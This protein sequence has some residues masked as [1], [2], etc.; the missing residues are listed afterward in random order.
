MSVVT[1]RSLEVCTAD[2]IDARIDACRVLDLRSRR[3]ESASTLYTASRLPPDSEVRI[4]FK[5]GE[6]SKG[7]EWVRL[8]GLTDGA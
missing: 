3:V 4:R 6:S 5:E 7:E 1:G 2:L 8:N